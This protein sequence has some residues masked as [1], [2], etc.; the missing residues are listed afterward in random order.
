MGSMLQGC[1]MLMS[2]NRKAMEKRLRNFR[3][4]PGR[5][6]RSMQ[7][8]RLFLLSILLTVVSHARERWVY[9]PANYQADAEAD[10]VISL[11]S[12]AKSAKYDHALISDSKFSRIDTL[13]GNY[14]KNVERVKQAAAKLDIA[15]VPAVFPVGYSNDLLFHDPNLAEGLPVKDSLFVVKDGQ[16]THQPD[17]EVALIGSH[18]DDRKAWDFL[19]DNMLSSDGA[20]HSPATTENAR[21][22]QKLKVA[23]FRQ[24]HV[25]VRIRSKGLK[26]GHP[27]I[28]AL[29]T[30]GRSLQWTNLGVKPDQDWTTHHVTFNSLKN[31]EIS[32][33]F[34]IWGGHQGDVWWDDATFE[35]CGLVNLLK[36]NGAPLTIRHE[37]G[38]ALFE[39]VDYDAPTDP[40]LGSKPWPGEYMAWHVS[41]NI[42]THGIADGARLRVSYYHP[43]VIYDGQ[44]CGCVEEPAFQSL[45]EDQAKRV[46]RLWGASSHLMSHDEWRVIGWDESC[47]MSG[48]TPGQIAAENLRFCTRT[49]K[50]AAPGTRILVWS[51]MFDPHHN[52]V[53]D[54]YLA[55][56]ALTDSWKGLAPD[57]T[58]MNWNFSKREKSLMFFAA[59]GNHQVIAGYYDEPI[60]NIGK[61]I[62]SAKIIT[63]VDGFMYTTWKKDYSKLEE[64][65]KILD[66]A[67]F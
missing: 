5:A 19:D 6:S 3:L 57:V 45:L 27:E 8:M 35:E 25:S 40:L 66:S 50:D 34:G 44:V 15:L 37:T 42:T 26:G 64:L 60:E 38:A 43:H 55:N 58:V 67:D 10:R 62:E 16:A 2:P 41:P 21:L 31:D 1:A 59:R 65:S 51:D 12:R 36:R 30:G 48:R 46:T 63:G 14:F 11:L 20:M 47:R 9:L 29:G 56:G 52:A 7:W 28:K 32:L 61:W 18:M 23:A 49:L 54:Y 33:Y 24:Y 4:K 39:G 22:H 13:P 53:D 17:S